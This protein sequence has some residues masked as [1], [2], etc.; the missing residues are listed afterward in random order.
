MIQTDS[1]R[2]V[3]AVVSFG[4]IPGVG[5]KLFAVPWPCLQPHLQRKIF[6]LDMDKERLKDAPGF[7]KSDSPYEDHPEWQRDVH[8]FY[9]RTPYWEGLEHYQG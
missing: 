2:V 8:T 7:E 6:V 5:N 3:Y 1:G 9:T 4:W